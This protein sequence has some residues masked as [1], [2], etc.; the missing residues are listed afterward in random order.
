MSAFRWTVAAL[1]TLGGLG[2]VLGRKRLEAALPGGAA[3]VSPP[4]SDAEASAARFEDPP[5][6]LG[7]PL[8]LVKGQRYRV[9]YVAANVGPL[10]GLGFVDVK[11][12]PTVDL[13]PADWPAATKSNETG[14][15]SWASG[16]WSGGP[17][18]EAIVYEAKPPDLLAIWPTA[19]KT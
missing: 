1:L 7:N 12:Y 11:T 9:R 4:P 6:Y 16:V 14:K 8:K 2:L 5:A 19:Q 15:I 3:P 13:L 10:E 17:A 18:S